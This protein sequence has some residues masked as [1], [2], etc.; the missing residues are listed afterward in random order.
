[1]DHLRTE[2]E[3]LPAETPLWDGQVQVVQ[4]TNATEQTMEV[5]FLMSAKNSG[6]AW[7]LRVHI[8]EKMI[9]YLQREHP[10][11]LPKSRV[12]LEKE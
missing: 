3:R 5:R 8:R 10:E 1:M 12:A 6:Q 4:V 7:D 9:G 11:A 2:F